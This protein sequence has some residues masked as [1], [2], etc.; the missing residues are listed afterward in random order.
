[1]AIPEATFREES[2]HVGYDMIEQKCR[3]R[4]SQRVPRPRDGVRVM[5][6]P[7]VTRPHPLSETG[8]R[9]RT[10]DAVPQSV[11]EMTKERVAA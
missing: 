7:Y 4:A 11:L 6:Y 8:H 5:L 2:L 10:C 3:P 1:M 9:C